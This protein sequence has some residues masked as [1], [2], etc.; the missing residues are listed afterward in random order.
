MSRASL[1]HWPP[2]HRPEGAP[3][4]AVNEI[5]VAAP[6]ARVWAWLVR[7]LTWPTYY[8]NAWNVRFEDGG[9]PELVLGSRFAWTTFYVRVTTTVVELEPHRRLAWS[10]RAPGG[11]GY[12]GWVIEPTADGCRVVTEET[13]RGLVP[14]LGRVVLRHGLEREHQRWLVG[15]ARMAE[16]G[17]L[18]DA[19]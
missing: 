6:P 2:E 12:H 1:V 9:G 16:S 5:P 10:G 8:R 15:L 18:P 14:S 7:P 4:F 19:A 13:Q 3:V 17:R 11:V